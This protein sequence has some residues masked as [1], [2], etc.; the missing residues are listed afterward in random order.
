MSDPVQ[1]IALEDG[2]R[3]V[4]HGLSAKDAGCAIMRL[5]RSGRRLWVARPDDGAA[6]D[7]F[8]AMALSGDEVRADTFQGVCLRLDLDTGEVLER[9]FVK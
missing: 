1:E 6:Q 8:V 5:H 7:A 2:G 3:L 4:L 9:T